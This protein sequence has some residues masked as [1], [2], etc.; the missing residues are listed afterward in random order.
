MRSRTG[1]LLLAILALFL[2]TPGIGLAAPNQVRIMLQNNTGER[3][4]IT[5]TGP[6][7]ISL[8]LP[9]KSVTL[10]VTSGDYFYSYRACGRSFSG[11]FKTNRNGALLFLKPCTS[12]KTDVGT[13]TVDWLIVNKTGAALNLVFTGPKTYRITVPAGKII[14]YMIPGKYTWTSSGRG[15]GNY[16]KDSGKI[17]IKKGYYW[18]WYC[19]K[20]E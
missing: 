19:E 4:A 1:L 17:T 8:T 9:L 11:T 20:A 18:T 10:R 5:M 7:R 15:C 16:E 12:Q 2:T 6:E 13:A 14:V 3:V